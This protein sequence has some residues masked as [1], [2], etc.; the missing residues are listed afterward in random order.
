MANTMAKEK[1]LRILVVG[2]PHGSEKL[3]RLDTNGF[4]VA[5]VTGDMGKTDVMRGLAWGKVK[6]SKENIRKSY[7][8]YVGSALPVLK[9]LSERI[10]VLCVH[11]NADIADDD[12]AG[13]NKATKA[14]IP[15]FESALAKLKNQVFIDYASVEL[16]GVKIAGISH[17]IETRWV[18]EFRGG[19]MEAM[20]L[21]MIEEEMARTFFNAVGKVDILVSHQP[22]YGVLDRVGAKY[23]PKGWVGKHAGSRL[24]LDYISKHK[25]RYVICGHIHEAR[26]VKK[27]GKTTV[28]NAG[29]CGDWQRLEIA[30]R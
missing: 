19:G 28:I 16:N 25:P 21:A 4:D 14:K 7:E 10:P 1:K 22:P 11:G 29:C 6:G 3:L 9:H 23:A 27:V 26:G 12:I 5:I 20:L 30:A 18:H 2:D 13:V 17:F 8:D 24:L 15:L